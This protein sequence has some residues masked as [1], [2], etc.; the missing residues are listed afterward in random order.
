MIGRVARALVLVGVAGCISYSGGARAIDRARLTTEPGW[1]V[2]APTP[3]LR[4]AGPRDC[5]AAALAMVAGRWDTMRSVAE[6]TAALPPPGEQG[7]RLGDLRD[8]ARAH[9]LVAFAIAGDRDALVHELRAGWPV[10]LGLILPYGPKYVQSHYEVLVGVQLAHDQFVTIDPAR[11][12][13]ARSWAAL[14]AEWA[15]AGRPTLIVLGP[16]ASA[17]R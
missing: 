5:G 8:A 6:A 4:Q 9:G 1:I 14:E 16:A 11:G 10:I 15:P 12:W 13:R 2:A 7:S 17:A 3:T